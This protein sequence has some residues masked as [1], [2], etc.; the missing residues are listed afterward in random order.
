MAAETL[1]LHQKI[2]FER[3]SGGHGKGPE[4]KAR[5]NAVSHSRVPSRKHSDS[6]LQEMWCFTPIGDGH[7][8]GM[9]NVQTRLK[10]RA[11]R[12][13]YSPGE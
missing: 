11:Q 8:Q 13:S 12:T 9:G 3:S 1:D 2:L 5:E 7:S 4:S 10:E 6:S